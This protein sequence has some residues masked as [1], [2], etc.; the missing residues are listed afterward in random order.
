MSKSDNWFGTLLAYAKGSGKLLV[1]SVIL[2]VISLVAGIVP[3]YCV[4]RII[5]AYIKGNL[6]KD[7][8]LFWGLIA[9]GMYLIKV[10]FFGFST[11]ISHYVAYNVLEGMR[12]KVAEVFM[13]APLGCLFLADPANDPGPYKI[14]AEQQ[15]EFGHQGREL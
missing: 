14:P 6:N 2:S 1:S 7:T 11:G 5:D 12:L 10:M 4:Y 15:A 13:K 9:L 8:A 3:Y